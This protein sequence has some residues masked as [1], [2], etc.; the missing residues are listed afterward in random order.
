MEHGEVDGEVAVSIVSSSFLLPICRVRCFVLL[1]CPLGL[2][3][4]GYDVVW[5]TGTLFNRTGVVPVR[6]N[7]VYA[8]N[9]LLLSAGLEPGA[10]RTIPS[11]TDLPRPSYSIPSTH[12]QVRRISCIAQYQTLVRSGSILGIVRTQIRPRQANVDDKS[13]YPS[14]FNLPSSMGLQNY[15]TSS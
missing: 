9:R 8:F 4:A 13:T 5:Q 2:P 6:L 10:L 7:T 12:R 11:R 3:P 14:C 15:A 1:R